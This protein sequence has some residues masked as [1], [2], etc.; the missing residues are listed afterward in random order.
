MRTNH[1]CFGAQTH[2]DQ[3][4]CD[5]PDVRTVTVKGPDG[6]RF[7]TNWCSDCRHIAMVDGF[8]ILHLG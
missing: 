5:G 2:D 8:I 7:T 3:P 1:L 4:D 6:K